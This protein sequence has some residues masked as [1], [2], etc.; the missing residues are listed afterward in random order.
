VV[1][2]A[3]ERALGREWVRNV[4]VKTSSSAEPVRSLS[5]GNQQKVV[6]ARW[7]ATEPKILILDNPTAGIDVA[8]KMEIHGIVRDMAQKR[9][10]VLIISD[11]V[12]ELAHD[13]NRVFVLAGGTITQEI[14]GTELTAQALT[15]AMRASGQVSATAN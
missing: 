8:S 4:R 9:C 10:A 11:D 5:G 7:L 14:A 13:C 3:V 15:K 12:E 2:D 6:L 1:T